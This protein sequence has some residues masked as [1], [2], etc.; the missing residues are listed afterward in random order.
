[1]GGC[2]WVCEVEGVHVGRWYGWVCEVEGV[3]VE[4][5]YGCVCVGV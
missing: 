4:R 3:H 5:W 1:M 2:V